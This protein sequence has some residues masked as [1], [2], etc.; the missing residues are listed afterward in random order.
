MCCHAV[1]LQQRLLKNNHPRSDTHNP[2]SDFSSDLG[3]MELERI[4]SAQADV[5]PRLEKFLQRVPLVCQE[6]GVVA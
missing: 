1:F 4:I 3:E 2:S 6:K 5:Q